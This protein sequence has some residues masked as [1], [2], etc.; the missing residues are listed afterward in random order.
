MISLITLSN[1]LLASIAQNFNVGEHVI[2]VSTKDTH[3][4]GTSPKKLKKME[5][6]RKIG[7]K[8]SMSDTKPR[9]ILSE[10]NADFDD[11]TLANSASY[12]ADR[13]FINRI[14]K[15][16]NPIIHHILTTNLIDA[17]LIYSQFHLSISI[18]SIEIF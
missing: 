12:D 5:L 16:N 4:H 14:K 13:Q 9:K 3:D 17:I 11:E 10:I 2:I 6:R 1:A 15:K 8:A 18:S 7:L